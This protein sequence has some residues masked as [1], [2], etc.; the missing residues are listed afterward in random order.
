[1]NECIIENSGNQ[2]LFNELKTIHWEK[3]VEFAEV[4]CEVKGSELKIVYVKHSIKER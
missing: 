2:A 4:I 3:Y 1:M